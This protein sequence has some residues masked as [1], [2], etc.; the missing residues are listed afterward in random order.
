MLL[1]NRFNMFNAL[2]KKSHP[3]YGTNLASSSAIGEAARFNMQA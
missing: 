1:V 2:S 3:K